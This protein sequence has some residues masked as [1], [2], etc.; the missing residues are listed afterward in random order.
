MIKYSDAEIKFNFLS[1]KF[2][3]FFCPGN[4]FDNRKHP[5]KFKFSQYMTI[6]CIN[7]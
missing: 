5:K 6:L 2:C 1:L 4:I 7:I 3:N